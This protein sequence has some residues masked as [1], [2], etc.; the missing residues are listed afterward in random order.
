MIVKIVSLL[1]QNTNTTVSW[2]ISHIIN[3]HQLPV[4]GDLSHSKI[5]WHHQLL[6]VILKSENTINNDGNS[7]PASA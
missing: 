2:L 4:L 6:Y 5:I 1:N 7:C 3:F